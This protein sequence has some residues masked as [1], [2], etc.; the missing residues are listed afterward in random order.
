MSFLSNL[1][2]KS[3]EEQAKEWIRQLNTEQRNL[4]RQIG[5]VEREQQHTRVLMK[6]AAKKGDNDAV[7]ILALELV[8]SKK[9]VSR[10]RVAKVTM[11]SVCMSLK[12]Q[13]MQLK[14]KNAVSKSAEVMHHMN[15]LIKIPELNATMQTLSKE[16]SK[17][18]L[19]DE[20]MNDTISSTLDAEISDTEV[21]EEAEK[22]MTEAVLR[23]MAAGHLKSSKQVPS[24]QVD[25]EGPHPSK[26]MEDENA[27]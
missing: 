21:E 17:A 27:P 20:M 10:L 24:E 25:H 14:M 16:M 3:P 8:R 13:I 15:Q 6:Q 9:A 26:E 7:R 2:S 1:F 11:N 22:V 12:N 4:E 19:I 18:G 23:E 5:R